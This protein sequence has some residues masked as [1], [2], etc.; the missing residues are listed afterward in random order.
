ME[1]I[2]EVT[3]LAAQT[4]PLPEPWFSVSKPGAMALN[5]G[6]LGSNPIVTPAR[7]V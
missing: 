6:C 4:H 1:A 2:S 7:G 3:Q 5:P